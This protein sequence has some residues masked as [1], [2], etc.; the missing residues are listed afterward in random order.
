MPRVFISYRHQDA[1]GYA[2][3]IHADLVQRLGPENVF[4][5]IISLD[6]GAKFADAIRRTL[7]DCDALLVIIGRSWLG[8][9]D[10]NG[11]RRLELE[12]DFVRMEVA[13]ALDGSVGVIPVLVG[14]AVMPAR[15]ELP[16]TLTGLT[17]RHAIELSDRWWQADLD[18]LVLALRRAKS[19]KLA[20][21]PPRPGGPDPQPT[22]PG[23]PPP[24]ID[25]NPSVGVPPAPP[26]HD[27]TA[28]VGAPPPPPPLLPPPPPGEGPPPPP[29]K[30][31][32]YKNPIV[33]AV[34]LAVVAI[35]IISGIIIGL[36]SHNCTVSGNTGNSGSSGTCVNSGNSLRTPVA[37]SREALSTHL[38]VVILPHHGNAH[39]VRRLTD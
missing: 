8:V 27:P 34:T 22:V 3:R 10:A 15:D 36:T 37:P 19:L 14:G 24:F 13:H 6:P 39:V 12:D 29:P 11:R 9:K 35:A 38:V 31:R 21:D 20:T 32:W 1:A 18:S 23:P 7:S 28:S 16:D 2:G 5:D 17:E 30:R 4:I 33:L 25:P 26:P